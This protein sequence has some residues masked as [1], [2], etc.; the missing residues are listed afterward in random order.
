ML[1]LPNGHLN[2]RD[3]DLVMQP[4]PNLS[5]RGGLKKE[6]QGLDEIGARFLDR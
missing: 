4:M 5:G 3:E 2:L 1:C 6:R